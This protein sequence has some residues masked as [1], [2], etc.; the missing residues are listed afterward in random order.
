MFYGVMGLK[1][2]KSKIVNPIAAERLNDFN[3]D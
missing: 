3:L 2:M 1:K